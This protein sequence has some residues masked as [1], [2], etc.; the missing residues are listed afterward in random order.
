MPLPIDPPDLN[1]VIGP[2]KLVDREQLRFKSHGRS[3]MVPRYLAGIMSSIPSPP[4]TFDFSKGESLKFPILGN[5]QYGDC[6]YAAAA[7]AAQTWT[8]NVGSEVSF[9]KN[10]LC[11]RYLQISGGD[12]GLDDST[13]FPEFKSGIVGPNGPHKIL[14]ELTVDPND[15]QSMDLALWAFCGMIWTMALGRTWHSKAAPGM[16]WDA[17]N[18]GPSIGGHATWLTGKNAV[19]YDV[20]TWGISPPIKL[21]RA[22]LLA[23]DSE[24]VVCFSMEMF[25]SAGIAPCGANYDQLATLWVQMGGKPLPPNPFPPSQPLDWLIQP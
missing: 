24:L 14:D 1:P 3:C 25:N 7:H 17:S 6:Y 18:K 13:I 9:D 12:N 22:G 21:T 23:A 8:G 11:N 4:A 2:I 5:D 19:G 20:R 16:T 15:Q 10:A